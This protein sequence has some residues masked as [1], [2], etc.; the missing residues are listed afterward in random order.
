MRSP[1]RTPYECDDTATSVTPFEMEPG[2][3]PACTLPREDH[4]LPRCISSILLL[5]L[6]DYL[7]L[8]TRCRPEAFHQ[9]PHLSR[10]G[11]APPYVGGRPNRR[12]VENDESVGGG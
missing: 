10:E 3:R 4:R 8:E 7:L 5:A 9:Y 1:G 2:T 11:R 12:E 6:F